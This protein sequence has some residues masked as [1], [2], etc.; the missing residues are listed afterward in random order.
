MPAQ[1]GDKRHDEDQH[2]GDARDR[3]G[4]QPVHAAGQPEDAA[5]DGQP[6]H[7]G[8]D[9]VERREPIARAAALAEQHAAQR[10]L[11]A[12]QHVLDPEQVGQHVVA[13]QLDQ[14]IEVEQQRGDAADQ[15]QFEQPV[16]QRARADR[17]PQQRRQ[18]GHQKVGGDAGQADHRAAPSALQEP[19]GRG[20]HIRRRQ[21][22]HEGYAPWHDPDGMPLG[23]GH[24][25][26]SDGMADLVQQLGCDEQ[27]IGQH[28][29]AE[30]WVCQPGPLRRERRALVAP[31][32]CRREQQNRQ[33]HR[34]E[35]GEQ[36]PEQ[37]SRHGQDAPKIAEPQPREGNA[38]DQT[39]CAARC[40]RRRLHRAGHGQQSSGDHAGQAAQQCLFAVIAW[41][42]RRQRA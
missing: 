34:A 17:R 4:Q 8:D 24:P 28:G 29:I 11:R 40:A 27:Q 10:L 5:I 1:Q 3:D 16:L 42:R 25:A 19:T 21:Q 2:S 26:D 22:E 7:P 18:R 13:I 33:H 23:R 6:P 35:R 20:V 12:G 36:P 31:R 30:G 9:R 15:H 14:R 38:P 32:P 37:R 41:L 39:E